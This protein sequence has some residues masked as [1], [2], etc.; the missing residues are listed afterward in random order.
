[1]KNH[2]KHEKYMQRCFDLAIK[3]L[4]YTYPNPLVGCVIVKDEKII[5]EGWHKRAGKDHAE[6]IAIKKIKE[7]KD[8][9]K[10]TLYVNLEPCN[11]IG[12]TPPC[13]D[14]IIKSGIQNVVI[15]CLDPNI[16]VKG[17][18]AEKLKKTG[19]N[20]TVGVCEN[21]AKKLNKRFFCY[22]EKKRPYVILK[23]AESKYG[24]IGPEKKYNNI[25]KVKYLTKMKDR[26]LVHKWRKE[27][28]SILIGV[29]TLIDDNPKLT[30]R[31]T[32][33]RSPIKILFDP[34]NRGD[35]NSDFF[36]SNDFL[37]VTNKKLKI[38]KN[39]KNQF[40]KKAIKLL[41]DYRISS[42]L[43]EG[44]SFTI[45]EF[46]NQKIFDEIRIFKTNNKLNSGTIAPILPKNIEEKK[47]KIYNS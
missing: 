34:N 14:L 37:H 40:L 13:T 16:L 5:S 39:N 15:G 44:G 22:H 45:Q 3:S 35:K 11:H 33:G 6:V 36:K 25:G 23:W 31:H 41:F 17:K 1:M 24:F 20:V 9:K 30:N 32:Q 26:I 46:I 8:L 4:G 19:I 10:S 12:K 21:Q 28:E 47:V 18:G 42:I 38:K 7:K 2:K 43:V 27:E 29:Q